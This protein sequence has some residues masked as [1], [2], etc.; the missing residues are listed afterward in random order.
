MIDSRILQMMLAKGV[1]DAAIRRFFTLLLEEDKSVDDVFISKSNLLDFGFSPQNIENIFAQQNEQTAQKIAKELTDCKVEML[2][3]LDSQYP[4]A[5]KHEKG[6]QQPPVLFAKGNI[7]LL[8]NPAVG[9]CGS[10][11]ASIKGINITAD[12]AKQLVEQKITVVSGYASGTDLAAHNSALKQGG[13]TVFVLAEGILRYTVKNEVRDLLK[14]DNHVFLSQFWPTMTWNAGNAMKRNGIIIGLSQAM[15]LVE[16]G[17]TGGTFAAGE[18]ALRRGCPLF[19]IDFAKPEVSAEA[20]PYFIG[21]GGMPIRG[22]QGIPRLEAVLNTVKT[23][24]AVLTDSLKDCDTIIPTG[25]Q[26]R[27]NI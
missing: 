3:M 1:G 13:N 19:V 25:E 24:Y 12:C 11:K 10:R 26:L 8:N 6:A 22:R 27:M 17:K 20:N 9:F 5:F 18:E 15:I 16:S 14:D 21:A 2:T 7:D 23:R 4:A